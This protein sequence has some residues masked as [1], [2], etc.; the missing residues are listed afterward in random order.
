MVGDRDHTQALPD[1]GVN[2]GLR[3]HR[4]V[5]HVVGCAVGVN[6]QVDGVESC[7]VVDAGDVL[8]LSHGIPELTSS[9]D[10]SGPY[11]LA[12]CEYKSFGLLRRLVFDTASGGV[13][14]RGLFCGSAGVTGHKFVFH[15]YSVWGL[16]VETGA[17]S[18]D[19]VDA[20][21]C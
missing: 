18:V 21:A 3:G 12:H 19:S 14:G 8:E 2:D 4:R 6:V 1:G 16:L 17:F 13:P 7:A 5:L 10:P 11:I 20:E 9:I 15:L